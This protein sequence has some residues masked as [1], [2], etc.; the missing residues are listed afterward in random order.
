MRGDPKEDEMAS[1]SGKEKSELVRGA[2]FA[3]ALW[4]ALEAAVREAGGSDEDIHRLGTDEG[5]DTLCKMAKVAALRGECEVIGA[6]NSASATSHYPVTV[7]YSRSMEQMVAA[8]EYNTKN[9][10]I[11]QEHFPLQGSDQIEVELH[12]VHLNRDA[13]TDSVLAE[14]DNQGRRPA[15]LPELLAFGSKYPNFQKEF[16]IMALGSVWQGWGGDRRVACL[17]RWD[18]ERRLRLDW[19]GAGWHG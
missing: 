8:G 1:K 4:I 2:G 19:V 3:A 11:T 7:D 5:K 10:N 18:G 15:T 13:S 14:L 12:L 6:D 9:D 16:P 17:G